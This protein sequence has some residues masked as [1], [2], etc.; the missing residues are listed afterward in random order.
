MDCNQLAVDIDAEIAVIHNW[1]K[2]HY[3]PKFPELESLVHHPID[4]A[5]VVSAIGNEVR[6]RRRGRCTRAMQPCSCF[7]LERL[8]SNGAER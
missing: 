7:S 5:R 2:V 8:Q 4:Y 3:R 1:V 6:R